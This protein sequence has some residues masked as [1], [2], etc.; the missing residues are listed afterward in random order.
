MA[1]RTNRCKFG[2][3]YSCPEEA[4]ENPI[5]GCEFLLA[6]LELLGEVTK[7]II[8]QEKHQS[9]KNHYHAFIQYSAPINT[10][11]ARLFDVE[12]VHPNLIHPPIGKGWISYCAKQ[13][14]FITNFYEGGTYE[15]A[16]KA[17]TWEEARAILVAGDPRTAML[18]YDRLQSN[19]R[20]MRYIPRPVP[21]PAGYRFPLLDLDSPQYQNKTHIVWGRAGVGKTLWVLQH[22]K[23]NP[24]LIISHMDDLARY[25]PTK[26]GGLLFDD[27]SFNHIPREA[28]IHLVDRELPRSLNRRYNTSE[29]PAGTI[30]FI[31]TNIGDGM[32]LDIHD[33]AIARRIKVH[34]MADLNGL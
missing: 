3:T 28:Q 11:N 30:T 16:L 23:E 5:T 32:C 2:L 6:R 4:D 27:M 15:R 8:C 9:G 22:F 14:D 33:E 21:L 19:W 26:Y 17:G 25:C 13:G 10:T 24:P 7:Y 12:G 34:H 1:F 31:T 29:V 18:S 20:A